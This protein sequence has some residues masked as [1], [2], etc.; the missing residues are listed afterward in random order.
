LLDLAA[1]DGL[2]LFDVAEAGNA[3]GLLGGGHCCCGVGLDLER[4]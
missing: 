1:A 2:V 3:A 4:C